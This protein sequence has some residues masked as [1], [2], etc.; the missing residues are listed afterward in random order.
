MSISAGVAKR[1]YLEVS[2]VRGFDVKEKWLK[3]ET[4]CDREYKL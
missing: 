3:Y 2:S 1:V 4:G